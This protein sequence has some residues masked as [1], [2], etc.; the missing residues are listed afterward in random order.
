MKGVMGVRPVCTIRQ[1][2]FSEKFPVCKIIDNKDCYPQST[3]IKKPL[4]GQ[5][6]GGVSV[7]EGTVPE[8]RYFKYIYPSGTD[9]TI[10]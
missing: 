4:L 9:S 1:E 5:P 10:V 2:I 7:R 3:H 8:V 6:R